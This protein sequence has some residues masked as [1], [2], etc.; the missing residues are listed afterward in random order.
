MT[1]RV[2]ITPE[3]KADIRETRDWAGG[4]GV[5]A[6]A[7]RENQGRAFRVVLQRIF[8]RMLASWP[9]FRCGDRYS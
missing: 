3:A 1:L 8:S 9:D 7:E 4:T 6:R 5:L 2:V